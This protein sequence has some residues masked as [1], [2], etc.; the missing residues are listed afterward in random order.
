VVTKLNDV[1]IAQKE[2]DEVA[3]AKKVIPVNSSGGTP[4]SGPGPSTPDTSRVTVASEQWLDM[5]TIRDRLPSS[6][7]PKTSTNSFS[8]TLAN[9]QAPIPVDLTNYA[10]ETTQLALSAKLPASLGAKTNAGSLSVVLATD[11]TLPLPTG[12][13]TEATLQSVANSVGNIGSGTGSIPVFLLRRDYSIN[14]VTTTTDVSLVANLNTITPSVKEIE[15]F[16]SS[17]QTLELK[18]GGNSRVY[19][20]PG[21]NGRIP[22]N[23]ASGALEIRATSANANV[24]ELIINFYG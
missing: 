15:I 5:I 7:G 3:R 2:H 17:G 10:L 8:V 4:D 9:D 21:G 14:P 18:V 16:D 22:F 19:V 1:Q 12:A 6:L 13:A 24:G 23:F 11:A 20:V